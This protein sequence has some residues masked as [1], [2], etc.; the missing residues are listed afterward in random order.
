MEQSTEPPLTPSKRPHAES[1]IV[2][3]QRA[4]G[5][6]PSNP[7]KKKK[8]T[9]L[10]DFALLNRRKKK[11]V[12]LVTIN[13]DTIEMSLRDEKFTSFQSGDH[14]SKIGTSI[15]NNFRPQK[16]EIKK[17]DVEV[18][19]SSRLA[20]D[21]EVLEGMDNEIENDIFNNP[22]LA[23]YHRL[24]VEDFMLL[25]GGESIFLL[26][27][28]S[29][30]KLFR[31]YT[32]DDIVTF[33]S[34]KWRLYSCVVQSSPHVQRATGGMDRQDLMNAFGK[35]NYGSVISIKSIPNDTSAS[36]L[37]TWKDVLNGGSTGI[38]LWSRGDRFRNLYS[39][40]EKKRRSEDTIFALLN[41][42]YHEVY[43]DRMQMKDWFK[44]GI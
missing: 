32:P 28:L 13:K 19:K 29:D 17:K 36:K 18:R 21:L 34:N 25:E 4:E 3:P 9:R 10:I 6:A 22:I 15:R 39:V 31:S 1:T 38:Q 44:V 26:L 41:A 35:D 33:G 12:N 30:C 23:E 8:Q 37:I 42:L 7:T 24:L 20:C 2:S 27:P 43:G 16:R 11:S 5:N 14:S 40:F